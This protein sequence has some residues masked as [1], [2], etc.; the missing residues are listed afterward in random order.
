MGRAACSTPRPARVSP[1]QG[2]HPLT[3]LRGP[4]HSVFGTN[5]FFLQSVQVSALL[6][7][8]T[9][10]GALFSLVLWAYF[11]TLIGNCISVECGNAGNKCAVPSAIPNRSRE[12][13]VNHHQHGSASQAGELN[14]WF[15]PGPLEPGR[16]VPNGRGS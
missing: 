14:R 15:G 6:V 2:P 8:A 5:T 4:R 1:L 10:T 11:S 3:R 12:C 13:S 7:A 9:S 16:Q